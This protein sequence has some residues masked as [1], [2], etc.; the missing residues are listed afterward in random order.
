MASGSARHA[1]LE[2][3]VQVA[4][5]VD[6]ST[7]EDAR[8]LSLLNTLTQ[9]RGLMVQGVAREVAVFGS[10]RGQWMSGKSAA[11]GCM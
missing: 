8:A 1:E 9:L 10:L 5:A 3:E 7:R 2:A 4:V 11:G 6:V